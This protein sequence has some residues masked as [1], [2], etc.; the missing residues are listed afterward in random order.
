MDHVTESDAGALVTTDSLNVLLAA[1]RR[2]PSELGVSAV[3]SPLVF[4]PADAAG[5]EQV[6][7]P[8]DVGFDA[9]FVVEVGAVD[10]EPDV[11]LEVGEVE[12]DAGEVEPEAAAVVLDEGIQ[13]L[14]LVP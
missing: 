12:P 10:V 5:A 14:L 11:E 6:M 13:Q 4:P 3:I 7:V 1:N 2:V 9:E 8:L